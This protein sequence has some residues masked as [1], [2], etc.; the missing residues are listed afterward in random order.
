MNGDIDIR[1]LTKNDLNIFFELR[2]EVLKNFPTAF[3]SSYD[4]EKKSSASFYEDI[5]CQTEEDNLIFGAFI[6]SK[7]IGSIRRL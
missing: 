6:S 1:R 2:L 3:L 4:E 5:L 7:L